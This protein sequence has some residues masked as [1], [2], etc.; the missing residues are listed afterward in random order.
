MA[1]RTDPGA[2]RGSAPLQ[3]VEPF[4][5]AGELQS[6]RL[7]RWLRL[8]LAG[9]LGVAG[10]TA[11]LGLPMAYAIGLLMALPMG[12][13]LLYVLARHVLKHASGDWEEGRRDPARAI[14]VIGTEFLLWLAISL[15]SLLGRD[16]THGCMEGGQGLPLVLL[17][18]AGSGPAVW[19]TLLQRYPRA[20][21]PIYVLRLACCCRE[22][23]RQQRAVAEAIALV[24]QRT[25]AAQVLLAGHGTGGLRAR[26]HAEV[27]PWEVAGLVC[28]ATPHHGC[29]WGR[30]W[31]WRAMGWPAP[32]DASLAAPARSGGQWL[33]VAARNL[34]TPDDA[35]VLPARSA[36]LGAVPVPELGGL[37]HLGC[38][39]S[40][41]GAELVIRAI[42]GLDSPDRRH[43]DAQVA[44][45]ASE[46]Q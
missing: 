3:R 12:W 28:I 18:G 15:R 5:Y 32:A 33:P 41:R 22:D 42:E 27:R 2:T 16:S 29:R 44:E 10:V 9:W 14:R 43:G 30:Y 7:S 17:H 11:W 36:A 26:F 37:G 40:L 24:R 21:R 31:P 20:R 19:Q 6:G 23:S 45:N 39:A 35:N 25:G 38:V 34:W 46:R 4:E 1:S 8:E 13:R